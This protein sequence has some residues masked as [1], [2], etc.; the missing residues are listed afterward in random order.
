MLHDIFCLQRLCHAYISAEQFNSRGAH[1]MISAWTRLSRAFFN[2]NKVS[3]QHDEILR[4][5][6]SSCRDVSGRKCLNGPE[7]VVPR[8]PVSTTL[9]AIC[10]ARDTRELDVV[11][12]GETRNSFR[13]IVRR[14]MSRPSS[15]RDL[16]REPR[17]YGPLKCSSQ[18]MIVEWPI[19]RHRRTPPL[20]GSLVRKKASRFHVYRRLISLHFKIN[21][22]Y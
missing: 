5:S 2:N 10:G 3:W 9:I 17:K 18:S 1:N 4:R 20:A 22:S 11:L 14:P 13:R 8:S 19:N 15:E 21:L 16:R 7:M 12:E 6:M